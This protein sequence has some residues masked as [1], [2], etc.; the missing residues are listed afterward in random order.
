M[1]SLELTQDF[2]IFAEG[3]YQTVQE[4]LTIS[5]EELAIWHPEANYQN[6]VGIWNSSIETQESMTDEEIMTLL[7]GPLRLPRQQRCS[8]LDIQAET[9]STGD[10]IM[11]RCSSPLLI[12][13]YY[14]VSHQDPYGHKV[15]K[16][17]LHSS[18][19]KDSVPVPLYEYLGQYWHREEWVS[20]LSHCNDLDFRGL[21]Q[22]QQDKFPGFSYVKAWDCDRG[23]WVRKKRALFKFGRCEGG[24]PGVCIGPLDDCQAVFEF[25]DPD[26]GDDALAENEGSDTLAP[27]AFPP[28]PET[29]APVPKFHPDLILIYGLNLVKALSPQLLISG[30][31]VSVTL[32]YWLYSC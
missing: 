21:A 24:E 7:Q 23:K 16:A 25:E 6:V 5:N 8:T 32:L 12:F 30:I 9:P 20:M 26:C 17:W 31:I 14:F 27:N 28:I 13:C 2:A 15:S 19:F 11:P 29:I 10:A 22:R 18:S 3:T 1:A 4:W